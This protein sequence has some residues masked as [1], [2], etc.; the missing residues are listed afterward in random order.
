MSQYWSNFMDIDIFPNTIDYWG[1]TG[2][3][4][5]RNQQARY[6][7]P[8]GEDEFSISIED[9]DTALT[10]GKFRDLDPCDVP[11]ADPECENL[12]ST[13]GELFQATNSAGASTPAR[14]S[15]PGAAT[16]SSCRWSTGRGLATT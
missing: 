2:M 6:S 9:P 13:L 8:M 1:P 10:V 14:A 4:F 5:Y 15:K 16:Y 11:N 7:F 12:E 3:V